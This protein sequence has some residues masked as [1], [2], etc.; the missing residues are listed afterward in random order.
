MTDE[1]ARAIRELIRAAQ[2]CSNSARGLWYWTK[3]GGQ[4][5][6]VLLD[7]EL[8]LDEAV[9]AVKEALATKP[10]AA[11]THDVTAMY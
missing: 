8:R 7:I 2:V 5:E 11:T 9:E 1:Q 3:A 4:S 6:A 10:D